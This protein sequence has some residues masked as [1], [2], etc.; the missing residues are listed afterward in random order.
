[1]RIEEKGNGQEC[2]G[3]LFSFCCNEGNHQMDLLVTASVPQLGPLFYTCPLNCPSALFYYP[4]L[5]CFSIDENDDTT[6][7][8]SI[9]T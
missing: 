9:D 4:K 5:Y 6:L 3:V 1:M 2:W 7:Y 8:C